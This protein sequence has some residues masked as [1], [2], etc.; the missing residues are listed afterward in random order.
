MTR[1]THAGGIIGVARAGYAV[2]PAVVGGMSVE[3]FYDGAER[4]TVGDAVEEAGNKFGL[5]R[6]AAFCRRR[7]ASRSAARHL[8]PQFFHVYFFARR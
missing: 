7:A 8:E 4:R 6:L 2:K 1:E 5:V 3:I